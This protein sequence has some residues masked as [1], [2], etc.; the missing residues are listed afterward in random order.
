MGD[1]AKQAE[2]ATLI[3]NAE[4]LLPNAVRSFERALADPETNWT[5]RIDY[6]EVLAA[7]HVA[8]KI[9]DLAAAF[10]NVAHANQL[11]EEVEE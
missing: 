4:A 8:A 5:T 3:R 2:W 6:Q 7:L 11:M 1:P 9:P 10:A